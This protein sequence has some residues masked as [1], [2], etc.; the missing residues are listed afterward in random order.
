MEPIPEV[1]ALR[2]Q[3]Q[4][5]HVTY[6]ETHL[7]LI[8][9]FCCM[10][11]I[12]DS[13]GETEAGAKSLAHAR[14]AIAQGRSGLGRIDSEEDRASLGARMDERDNELQRFEKEISSKHRRTPADS[15][16]SAR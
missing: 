15:A 10:S 9:T 3:L 13:I 2:A 8:R 5:H 16:E 14:Q 1:E 7:D 11:R 4:Q 12:E 6:V